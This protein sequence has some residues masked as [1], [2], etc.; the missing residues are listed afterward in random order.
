[1]FSDRIFRITFFVSLAVHAVILFKNPNLIPFMSH[2]QSEMVAVSYLKQVPQEK[3]K[4]REEAESKQQLAKLQ[5]RMNL[6]KI[7]PP[8][9]VSK[10]D[11]LR[12]NR[13]MK[14]GEAS[15]PKPA[16][17]KPDIAA[18]RKKIT[19]PPMDADKINNPSYISYYQIVREKIRRAAYQNYLSTEIGEVYLSF[20]VGNDG[21][22]RE[23]QL[24]DSKSSPVEFL[25]EIAQRS[26]HEAAPFPTFPGELDYPQLSFNVVISFEIE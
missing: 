5:S 10:E 1:M 6:K 18:V 14:L 26:I 9:F 13:E 17:I 11:V 16:L 3:L 25:R 8:P 4:A 21:S 7:A 15:F 20:I 2:R 22:L 23:V 24:V 12:I 19:L